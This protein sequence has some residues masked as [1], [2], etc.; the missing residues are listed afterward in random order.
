[1]KKINLKHVQY[2]P[3]E[4]DPD[5]LYVANE[6]DIAV[7]LCPCGCSSKIK[8]P[9]GSTE[10]ALKETPDGPTLRPSIGNWQI[11]CQ[12]H[13]WITKGEIKWAEKWDKERIRRGREF[14]ETRRESYYESLYAKKLSPI[15]RMISWFKGGKTRN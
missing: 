3:N 6:F 10:W 8:T 1:M 4:L 13:Y 7:H 12:S 5:I 2:I 14:E 9:L 11:P 15:Q